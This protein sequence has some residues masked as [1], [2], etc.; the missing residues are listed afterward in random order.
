MNAIT[1]PSALGNVV[2][3]LRDAV[4]WRPWLLWLLL[5]LL[6]TLVTAIPL[7]SALDA[8]F[9]Q[10]PQAADIAAGRA[11]GLLLDGLLTRD[12]PAGP[13]GSATL[14]SLALML[15][16]SPLLA[17]IAAAAWRQRG[18]ALRVLLREAADGYAPMLRM[19]LWSLVP[20]GVAAGAG[21]GLMGAFLQKASTAVTPDA[22]APAQWIFY[23]L[24][25]PLLVVAHATV[26]AGRGELAA[27]PGNRGAI[28]AW[29]Q[30]MRLLFKRPLAVL[31]VEVLTLA[32]VFIPMLALV[33][34][35]QSLDASTTGGWLLA[36]LVTLAGIVLI[37]WGR[38]ARLFGMANLARAGSP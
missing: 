3:A 21:G 25:L 12:F 9:G 26:E 31:L 36:L 37:G 17:S 35:R 27:Q 16:L 30:G 10:S 34:L 8:R 7:W 28:R 23:G 11:P 15:L 32:A 5:T 20:M 38:V 2:S 22:I 18:A 14:V 19:L 33:R 29:M 13:L 1:R 24:L 4:Q 6:P